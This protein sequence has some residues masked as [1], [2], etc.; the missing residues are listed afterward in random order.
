MFHKLIKF[1]KGKNNFCILFLFLFAFG[2]LLEK[3]L[4]LSIVIVHIF[5]FE[6]EEKK[7]SKIRCVTWYSILSNWFFWFLRF[8]WFFQFFRKVDERIKPKWRMPK[9]LEHSMTSDACRRLTM[10]MYIYFSLFRWFIW[11]VTVSPITGSH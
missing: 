11:Q 1:T 5:C 8:S 2:I 10:W 7:N 6:E 4:Y 3:N 9:E